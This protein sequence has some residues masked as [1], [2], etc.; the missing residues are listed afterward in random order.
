MLIM[1]MV[2]VR[3]MSVLVRILPIGLTKCRP[4][5]EMTTFVQ[6]E[7]E[8]VEVVVQPFLAVIPCGTVRGVALPALAAS[9]ITPVVL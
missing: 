1:R 6:V 5:S 7:I 4:L 9:S 3:I 2:V 8:A